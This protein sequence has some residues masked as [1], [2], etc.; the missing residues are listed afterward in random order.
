MPRLIRDF[1]IRCDDD[2]NWRTLPYKHRGT[3]TGKGYPNREDAELRIRVVLEA[4]H[5]GWPFAHPDLRVEA[6]V[7]ADSEWWGFSLIAKTRDLGHVLHLLRDD[8][9]P[10][11]GA[12]YFANGGAYPPD[13]PQVRG[14]ANRCGRCKRIREGLTAE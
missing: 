4:G 13:H 2:A 10:M 6:R 12:S 1:V 7:V 8:L 11:C 14:A 9:S 5:R 3:P